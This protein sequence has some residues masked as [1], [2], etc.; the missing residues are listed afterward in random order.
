M[1][2]NWRR[3]RRLFG[4]LALAIVFLILAGIG[5]AGALAYFAVKG[6]ATDLQAQLTNHLQLGQSELEAAKAS[7]KQANTTHEIE[8][9]SEAKAH[10]I[11]AK[12]QF[13][14]A[15]QIADD[16]RLLHQLEGVPEVGAL[17]RSRHTSVD[18]IAEMGVAISDA[19][20]DLSDLAGLLIKPPT[21][22]GQEGRTL[23][24]VL[25]QTNS[26]L[27][28][29]RA[30]F[31][32]AQ[33]AAGRVDVQVLPGGQQASFVK[34]RETIGTALAGLD[35]FQRLVPVLTEVLG[36]NG[37]RTYL[38]EQVNPAEL[39]PGGG[40]MGTYSVLRADHGAL[41]LVK[42]GNAYDLSDPRPV[43]G[44][45]GY[46]APPPPFRALIGDKSWSFIDSNFFPDF[47]SNAQVAESFAQP[48]LGMSIDAVI[49]IDY[50][51]A[52]KMLELTGPLQVPGYRLTLDANNFIPQL[53]EGELV[54]S[55]SHKALLGAIAGPL[56]ERV[57]T[58]PP[59]RWPAFLAALND[60]ATGRHLQVYFNSVTVENEIRR[61]GWSGDLNPT[62]S[63]EFMAE[64]ESNLGGNKS[65]YFVSRHYTVVLSRSGGTLHHKV[66]VDLV[67][68]MPYFYRP[69]EYYAAYIRLFVPEMASALSDNLRRGKYP[70][71]S[72]PA[73]AQQ[74]AG[75]LT[76]PGYGNRGQPTFEYDTPWVSSD[77][78][79]NMIYWQKQPG[80]LADSLDV[81]WND[82][83]G[84]SSTVAGDLSQDRIIVLSTSGVALTAAPPA[85]AKLPNLNFG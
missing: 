81:T 27:V 1:R 5:G 82:G 34:A 64:V 22:G 18:G 63:H 32:R 9:V 42:S 11:S 47:P 50:Y 12:V 44:Q 26:S 31:A 30:K 58:L 59:E 28:K 57:A 74:F 51:T 13:M 70:N 55:A 69:N 68:N 66:T 75:W 38:I 85:Q 39:R 56:M 48:R 78:G 20:L 60:L 65:N 7:L 24:T 37:A 16:S 15:G 35:E 79:R 77:L 62:A 53:I 19:G 25:E 29:V 4:A 21:G 52:A 17:A 84:H 36:G 76:I 43:Q 72:P 14:V 33:T 45:A 83:D 67:N 71:S 54:G 61:F 2:S 23:L 3:R 80:T 46:V 40:F 73:G 49:S 10:F 6:Q 41:K 8:L